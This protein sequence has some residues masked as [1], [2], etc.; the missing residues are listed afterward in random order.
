MNMRDRLVLY[1]LFIQN[2]SNSS[3]ENITK[4]MTFSNVP[5]IRH[6]RHLFTIPTKEMSSRKPIRQAFWMK[7]VLVDSS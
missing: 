4:W 5:R 7:L 6:P 1:K 3:F 2:M